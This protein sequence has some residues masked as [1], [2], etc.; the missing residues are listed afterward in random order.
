MAILFH[1]LDL[2]GSKNLRLRDKSLF[3]LAFSLGHAGLGFYWIPH[4]LQEFGG[5][6][7]P[8]NYLVGS[9]FSLIVVPQL[10][11]FLFTVTWMQRRVQAYR[12]LP[13]WGRHIL[14]A[15][16]LST[17]E[18]IVPQ[19]FPGHAGHSWLGM[20]PYLGLAPFGGVP[21]FSFFSYWLAQCVCQPIKQKQDWWGV[22]FGLLFVVING[23]S[24]LKYETGTQEDQ[25][26]IRLVQPNI[27]NFLKLDSER[28][29]RTSIEK[30]LASY[31]ELSLQGESDPDIII[32]PETAYPHL[33]RSQ[34]MSVDPSW[35]P[36][37]F[38]EIMAQTNA[39]MLIGGYDLNPKARNGFMG[40]Y[41]TAFH[42]SQSGLMKQLYHKQLLIPFGE[43]LPFGPFNESLSR[44]NTNVSFFAAGDSFP[45]FETAKGFKFATIICYETL[46]PK[47][48]S[49]YLNDLQANNQRP[50]F[51]LNLTNDSW[52]GDT[53][54]P[55]QHLFLAKWRSVEY[56][57][58]MVRSTNTGIT[59]VVYPDGSESTQTGVMEE[60]VLEISLNS[61]Q[62][63]PTIYQRYGLGVM[64]SIAIGL[65]GFIF[66]C[67]RLTRKT[68]A[69]Q[70]VQSQHTDENT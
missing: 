13:S 14:L 18:N 53:A 58:P 16:L 62:V 1:A 44:L 17:L 34:S 42:F 35:T 52:Y 11:L 23:L 60:T 19:Q 29:G 43:G 41:N 20:A 68:L 4:T 69:Y 2:E 45:L 33:L 8:W 57:L 32:W 12:T 56:N 55:W 51:L 61:H 9:L 65:A 30:V 54:E 38:K 6:F 15:L 64:W 26:N 10:W 36:R 39:E 24:P 46:F 37:L 7:F 59:S 70:I 5:L 63:A 27:G 22:C 67:L 66:L 3:L 50:D 48:V 49:Q 47:F 25:L 40:Q 21:L 28:G 31:K